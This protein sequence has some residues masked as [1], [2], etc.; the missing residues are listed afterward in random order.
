L[1]AAR[2]AAAHELILALPGGY[3]RPLVAEAPGLSGG[4]VQRVGLARA[5]YGDPALLILDEPNANLDSDGTQALNQAVRA[6]KAAG[7]AVILMAHRPVALQDCDLL[8]VLRDGQ[9]ADFGP[10]D[11]V[12]RDQVRNAGEIAQAIGRGAG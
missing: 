9:V 4:Q 5:L 3:D 8:L 1:R 2:A 12:L 7:A 11:R 6:A 10:R